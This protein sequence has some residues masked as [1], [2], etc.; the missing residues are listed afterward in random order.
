MNFAKKCI[1]DGFSLPD[2]RNEGEFT[3]YSVLQ[4]INKENI[5]IKATSVTRAVLKRRK[6]DTFRN[7]KT[8]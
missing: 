3:F 5:L 8:K 2:G 6:S 4:F 7:I 1:H